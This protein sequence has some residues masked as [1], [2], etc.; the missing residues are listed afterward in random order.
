MGQNE[1]PK[2]DLTAGKLREAISHLPDEH[3]LVFLKG[4]EVLTYDGI[5]SF[6]DA[7]ILYLK[8]RSE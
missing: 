1:K 3:P 5:R 6:E 4:K 2:K 7:A 8:K